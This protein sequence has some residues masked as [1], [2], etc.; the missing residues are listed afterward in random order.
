MTTSA[1]NEPFQPGQLGTRHLLGAM[2]I[3]AVV[4][5]LSA[6]QLRD[7]PFS[8]TLEAGLHWLLVAAIAA[9]AF[10][11][12][13]FVRR[14]NRER[15]GAVWLRVLSQP[16]TDRERT[17]IKWALTVGVVIDGVLLSA[18]V[19]PNTSLSEI[20]AADARLLWILIC[21]QGALWGA[22]LNHWVAN[23]YWLEFCEH[24][25][26][27]YHAFYP[28]AQI[29]RIGWSPVKPQTLFMLRKGRYEEQ[30]VDPAAHDAVSAVLERV[31]GAT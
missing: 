21:G 11:F 3:V 28:W 2:A 7:L 1:E 17:Q 24:G 13:A 8:R 23:V 26:L 29:T 4:A 10:A 27:S 25:V 14:R 31:R 5:A 30:S 12:G 9:G 22:C 6:A 19:L 15:A 20:Y 18:F 16:M